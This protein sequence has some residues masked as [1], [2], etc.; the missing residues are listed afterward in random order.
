LTIAGVH[1][2]EPASGN[3][4]LAGGTL[5][6]WE[7]SGRDGPLS[8]HPFPLVAITEDGPGPN[9]LGAPRLILAPTPALRGALGLRPAD[10]KFSMAD[11]SGDVVARLVVWRAEYEA[12]D[13]ELTY[14]RIQGQALLVR[15]D[16]MT[17]L[18]KSTPFELTSVMIRTLF[19]ENDADVESDD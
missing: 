18:A 4:P 5:R 7:K 16:R 1:A 2:G 13:Y 15:P 17:K 6:W 12:S 19:A 10:R 14:P 8:P 11:E 3:I 9:G